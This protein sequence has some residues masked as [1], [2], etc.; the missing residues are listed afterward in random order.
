M[1]RRRR[2]DDICGLVI[3]DKPAGVSSN[4]ALQTVR[5]SLNARKAGHGGSLDPLAE[6]LLPILLGDATKL[7]A[8]SLE[9]DKTYE[10]V[11]EFGRRTSTGDLDGE[12]VE[13]QQAPP[14]SDAE[15]ARAIAHFQG[16]Q[17]QIPPMYSALKRDGKPLYELA[18]A[19]QEVDREARSIHVYELSLL[20]RDGAQA[21]LRARVSKGTYIRTLAEDIARHC[22]HCAHLS[23]L[24]RTAVAG[25]PEQM[26]ALD[27]F[28][29]QSPDALRRL[30][31]SV[32]QGWPH[33]P[34]VHIDI[35]AEADF[36]HGRSVLLPADSPARPNQTA[37]ILSASGRVLGTA[38]VEGQVL[39]PERV[40]SV[41]AWQAPLASGSKAGL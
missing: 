1:S 6:G 25:L 11:M 37:L 16:A 26:V 21:K 18:R 40:F 17:E 5:R 31:L 9:G 34:R 19:G 8:Y 28:T 33:L 14:P 15:L 22:G 2:G 32:G 10:F 24:R 39:A 38:R 23:G 30:V 20:H 41:E 7:S 29:Q 27:A 35:D 12:T 36:G 3:L 13:I 4:H